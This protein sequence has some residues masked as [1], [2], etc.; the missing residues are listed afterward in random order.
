MIASA[1]SGRIRVRS[2]SLK[3][4]TVLSAVK[5]TIQALDGVKKV[6][7]NPEA[8]SLIVFYDIEVVSEFVMEE[9]VES[10]CD[11][12]AAS[13][14]P[15]NNGSRM[16]QLTKL[17]MVSTLVPTVAFAIAGKKKYHVYAGTAFLFFAGL[18]MSRYVERLLK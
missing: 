15:D 14:A 9:L 17:G 6:R 16:G 5:K 18:H 7:G 12:G 2:N 11:S 3:K 13:V 8:G 1:V 4:N 10:I